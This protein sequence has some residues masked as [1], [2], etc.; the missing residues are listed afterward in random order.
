SPR[1]RSK[2]SI[3]KPGRSAPS[4]KRFDSSSGNWFPSK[5]QGST[6]TL[7]LRLPTSLSWWAKL[8]AQV[9]RWF[10]SECGE[11]KTASRCSGDCLRGQ[12]LRHAP[13]SKLFSALPV[14]FEACTKPEGL[15]QASLSFSVRRH[16]LH[17]RRP[18]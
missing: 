18:F 10:A 14:K 12:P 4:I 8:N 7:S 16:R 13:F 11:P 6:C 5:T 17:L 15:V 9:S 3:G 2:S 1:Y